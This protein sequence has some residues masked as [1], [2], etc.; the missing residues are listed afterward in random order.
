MA[1]LLAMLAL[2]FLGAKIPSDADIA[3]RIEDTIREQLHPASVKV[4]VKRRSSLSTT[5][6]LLEISISG[7]SA[8]KLPLGPPA[9]EAQVPLA[10]AAPAPRPGRQVR[11]IDAHITCENFIINALPVRSL[12]LRGRDVRI[13]WQAVRTGMFEISAAQFVNGSLVLEEKGLTKY[14]RTLPDLPITEPAI[15]VTPEECRVSGKTRTLVKLPIQLSGRLAARNGAVLYLDEPSL[16]VSIVRIPGFVSDRVLKD[17][18]PLADLN[19]EFLLPAPLAITQTR[20]QHGL[21]RFDGALL[22]PQPEKK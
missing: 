14:L 10:A 17:I 3:I 21:L 12:E 5:V 6:D 11:I 9:G 2:G 15:S 20:L 4:V 22:F 19:A 18:N 1:F 7:F 16:R 13:P 8:D